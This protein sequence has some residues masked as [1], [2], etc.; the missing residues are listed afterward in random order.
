M[1]SAIEQAVFD[2]GASHVALDVAP[3]PHATVLWKSACASNLSDAELIRRAAV[4]LGPSPGGANGVAMADRYGGDGIGR[5]GGSG[6]NILINGL[7]VKGIG[8]TPLVHTTTPLSHASGSAYLE[9]CVREAIYAGV[10]AHDFPYGAV[11]ALAILDTGLV[12]D[13]PSDIKPAREA[14]TLLVRPR[15]VRPAHFERAIGFDHPGSFEGELD[16]QRVGAV[17]RSARST[18]G[19]EGLREVFLEFWKRWCHQLAYGFV[20]RLSHGNN[21]TSNIAMDGAL[22]DFGAATCLADW[23]LTATSYMYDPFEG[24]VRP[25]LASVES[26][27]FYASKYGGF[28]F[29]EKRDVQAIQAECVEKFRKYVAFEVLRLCGMTDDQAA[30][31]VGRDFSRVWPVTWQA[32]AT[33]Q[34]KRRDLMS[35]QDG[36]EDGWDMAKLWE[37]RPPASVAGLSAIVRS[38]VPSEHRGRCIDDSRRRC[39]TR[40]ALFKPRLREAFFESVECGAIENLGAQAGFVQSFIN[41]RVACNL[42]E[43]RARHQDKGARPAF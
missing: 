8:R 31:A 19:E 15:F 33:A 26:V 13:W 38:L 16:H 28:S 18:L 35:P 14:C 7:Q 39:Q 43:K 40:S 36:S 17:F 20:H 1:L 9:E 27:M 42:R 23:S 24:R 2:S 30:A 10:V 32:I 29:A 12:K 25:V 22:V 6:R 5:N 11:P 3:L 41:D 4:M 37:A 21:T 34:A